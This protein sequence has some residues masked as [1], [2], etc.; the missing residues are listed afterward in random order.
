[1]R[2]T[3]REHRIHEKPFELQRTNLESGCLRANSFPRGAYRSPQ[4]RRP[5]RRQLAGHV[6]TP[7]RGT[8]SSFAVD[9]M[10]ASRES[11]STTRPLRPREDTRL[12]EHPEQGLVLVAF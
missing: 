1:M 5:P 9:L 10:R 2:P 12:A 8:L 7:S 11:T 6:A 4:R 3:R